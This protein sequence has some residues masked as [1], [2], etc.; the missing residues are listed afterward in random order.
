MPSVYW[1]GVKLAAIGFWSSGNIFSGVMN[2]SSSSGSPKDES[3][4]GGFQ[5][6]ATCPNA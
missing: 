1:S 5:E 4:F 2:H 3:G 6:N